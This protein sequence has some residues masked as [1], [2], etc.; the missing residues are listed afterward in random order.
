MVVLGYKVQP[1]VS[2]TLK[3]IL[4]DN[5]LGLAGLKQPV[6]RTAHAKCR[7]RRESHVRSDAIAS[8][9]LGESISER[10][11]GA[12]ASTTAAAP[13]LAKSG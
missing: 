3:E 10:Q 9:R 7:E 8:K 11:R 6:G 4:D 12:P 2:K 1:L 5:L 13:T